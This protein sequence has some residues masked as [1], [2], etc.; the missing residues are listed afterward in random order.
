MTKERE[1]LREVLHVCEMTIEQAIRIEECLNNPTPENLFLVVR[2]GGIDASCTVPLKITALDYDEWEGSRRISKEW[3]KDIGFG[4]WS[5]T[6]IPENTKYS[7]I[8]PLN[9]EEDKHFHDILVEK[10]L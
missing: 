10:G 7:D 2:D 3:E 6:I 5:A 1:L 8:F 9:S 4:Q